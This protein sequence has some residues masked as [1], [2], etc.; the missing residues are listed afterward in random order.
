MKWV[1]DKCG[2]CC[3]TIT[4]VIPEFALEDGACKHYDKETKKCRIY[5][6]RPLQCRVD[7]LYDKNMKYFMSKEKYY[8]NQALMCKL[9]KEN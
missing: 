1:C 5:F 2:K 8:T 3:E 6:E 7:E 4:N 9:V